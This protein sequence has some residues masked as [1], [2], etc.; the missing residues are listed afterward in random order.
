[1]G[2]KRDKSRPRFLLGSTRQDG[3]WLHHPPNLKLFSGVRLLT[4]AQHLPR[5]RD[6]K[7][8]AILQCA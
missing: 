1:M 3:Q 7:R 8:R 5:R 4:A 6:E 2:E